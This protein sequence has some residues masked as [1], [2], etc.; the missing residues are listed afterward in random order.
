MLQDKK[1]YVISNKAVVTWGYKPLLTNKTY[2]RY[3]M[4]DIIISRKDALNQGLKSFFTGEPCNHGHIAA[5][6]LS[7]LCK[8]CARNYTNSWRKKNKEKQRLIS[9]LTNER[10]KDKKYKG[11][12]AYNIANRERVRANDKVIRAVA[13]GRLKKQ[14]CEVC[15]EAKTVGHHDDYN[16]PLLVRWLCSSCHRV[17]HINNKP[18]EARKS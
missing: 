10:R 16:F 14:S 18:I 12:V 11:K 3:V 15:G 13:S 2:L 6:Y 8:E 4:A 5:R 7:G 9:K 1:D 17:W